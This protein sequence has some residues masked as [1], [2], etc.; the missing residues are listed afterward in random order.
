MIHPYRLG[1]IIGL[2]GATVF[3]LVNRGALP[4]AW[5]T[6]ALVTYVV[7]VAFYLWAVW[8][9]P[10]STLPA[11]QTPHPRAG[12]VYLASVAGML[13]IF[14]IG[15]Q[16]LAS[17]DREPLMPALV[18]FGVGLH[19]V[20]FAAAFRAPVFR[21][22]GWLLAGIGLVGLVIGWLGAEAVAAATAAVTAGIVM[23]VVM[24][25]GALVTPRSG[26]TKLGEGSV[27]QQRP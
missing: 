13:L 17:V 11:G 12:L 14:F 22:L 20:P 21:T 26:R 4:G 9:R 8:L 2:I 24:G 5:S 6:V 7:A 16:V 27:E 1:S 15:R 10:A 3:V 25:S 19:F 23:L 18:A